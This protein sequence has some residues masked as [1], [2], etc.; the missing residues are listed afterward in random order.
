L[1]IKLE[2][3]MPSDAAQLRKD[4]HDVMTALD[5]GLGGE[6]DPPILKAAADEGRALFTFDLKVANVR[7]FPPETHAGIVVFRLQDQRWKTLKGPLGRTLASGSLDDL[8]GGLAIVSAARIRF[9]R[10]KA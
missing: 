5:E 8:A 2:E 1:R 10:P 3:N 9:K 4:G 6:S 7:D